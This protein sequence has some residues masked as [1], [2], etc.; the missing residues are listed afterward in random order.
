MSGKTASCYCGQ[1]RIEVQGEPLGIGICHCLACQQRTGSVF[2]ALASFSAPYA[3]V[4]TATEFVRTGD[5][6]SQFRFRFCPVCGST[7]F[8][9]EEGEDSRVSVAVGAFADP[10][11]PP[12]RVSVYEHRRHAWVNL[13]AAMA[14]Y[15]T[16][17]A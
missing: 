9:T 15:D 10:T 8:H 11:F 2:A 5:H 12:P 7:V 3:V 1:L 6:G 4:G 16:D 13:P 14:R 17:P